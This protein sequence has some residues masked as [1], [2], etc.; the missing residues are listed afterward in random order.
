MNDKRRELWTNFWVRRSQL[1]FSHWQQEQW[2]RDRHQ[3]PRASW[4]DFCKNH[5][6]GSGSSILGWISI[7]I[8]SGSRDGD[9]TKI[10]KNLQQKKSKKFSWSK[11]TGYLSLGLHKGSPSYRRGLQPSKENMLTTK[12]E[13][14]ALPSLIRILI[15]NPD[16][17]D[18]LTGSD[19]LARTDQESFP[20][21]WEQG[22]NEPAAWRN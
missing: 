8:Q 13:I 21:Q 19:T 5:C 12:H 14:S 2:E 16:S 18:P 9:D 7:R 20:S 11:T 17:G 6:F 4:Q 15:P 10:K 1:I 3:V 22:T